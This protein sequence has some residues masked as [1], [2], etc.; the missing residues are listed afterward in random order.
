MQKHITLDMLKNK[1]P[2]HAK[3]ITLDMLKINTLDML[4]I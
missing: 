2:R 1:H 3:H 4:K